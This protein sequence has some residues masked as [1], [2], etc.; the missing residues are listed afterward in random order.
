MNNFFS[1]DQ[2]L[3]LM[4]QIRSR[5]QRDR[6][7]MFHRERLLYGRTSPYPADEGEYPE[8]EETGEKFSTLPLRALLALGLFLLIVICDLSGRSF[9]GIQAAQCFS[10]ISENYD[11]AISA[12]VESV[13]ADTP[14]AGSRP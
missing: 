6:Y 4:R 2:K 3:E 10:A 12:W 1:V 13:S 7:D 9:L 11:D 5:Y 14:P 8:S